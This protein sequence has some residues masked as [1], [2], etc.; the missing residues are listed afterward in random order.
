MQKIQVLFPEP[1]MRRL[2]E[3][4]A[5]EDRPISELIRRATEAYLD[6]LPASDPGAE[7]RDIPVFDGGETLIPPE[8]MRDAAYSDRTGPLT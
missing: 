1:Q 5:R 6:R 7:P 4:A 8:Q 2:R 3:A